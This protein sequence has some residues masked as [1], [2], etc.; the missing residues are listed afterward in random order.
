M[1]EIALNSVTALRHERTAINASQHR[2]FA[3]G[4]KQN[5]P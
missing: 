5:K 1:F 4:T 2:S 3:S